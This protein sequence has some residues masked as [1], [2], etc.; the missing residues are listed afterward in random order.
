MPIMGAVAV[1][2]VVV[3]VVAA[4]AGE[5]NPARSGRHPKRVTAREGAAH[6]V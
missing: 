1:V 4:A 5:A 2:E 3:E 6:R